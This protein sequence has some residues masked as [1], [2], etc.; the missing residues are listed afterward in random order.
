MSVS[1]EELYESEPSFL[2]Q[3]RSR[4]EF[5]GLGAK[6]AGI[7]ALAGPL[8]GAFVEQAEAATRASVGVLDNSP[9]GKAQ[10][11]AL[12]A[13]T[14]GTSPTRVAVDAAKAFKGVTLHHTYE[15]GL[16]ALD[17][18]LYSGPVWKQL[19]GIDVSVVE[20]AH[21]DMYSKAIAE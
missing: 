8:F 21:P 9:L 10:A 11:A 1:D 13:S 7:A 14:T 15:A 18:K 20:L 4:R 17:P 2:E 6:A 12:K 5:L 16:Q 19:T 3:P